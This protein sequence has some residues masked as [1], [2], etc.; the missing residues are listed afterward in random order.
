MKLLATDLQN[1]ANIVS[2]L[3]RMKMFFKAVNIL[4]LE[5]TQNKK[6]AALMA[7]ANSLQDRFNVNASVS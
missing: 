3:G 1:L 4:H 5:S 7:I 6:E 2:A